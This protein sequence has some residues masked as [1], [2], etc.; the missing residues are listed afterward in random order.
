VSGFGA[1]IPGSKPSPTGTVKAL[2]EE[3]VEG[4]IRS[5][6]ETFGF[7]EKLKRSGS[8]GLDLYPIEGKN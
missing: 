5:T 6:T 8:E 3:H 7:P 4:N 1:E 2:T